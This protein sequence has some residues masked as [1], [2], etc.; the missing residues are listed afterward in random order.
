MG[1]GRSTEGPQGSLTR[2]DSSPVAE[3]V[4]ADRAVADLARPQIEEGRVSST[5]RGADGR[6]TAL[7]LRADSGEVIRHKLDLDSSATPAQVR[8]A[9]AAALA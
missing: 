6:W 2:S 5:V 8:A 7:E 4:E 1:R 3:A 9:A